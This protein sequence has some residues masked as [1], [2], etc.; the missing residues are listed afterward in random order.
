MGMDE[1]MIT[2]LEALAKVPLFTGL[3]PNELAR[4]GALV[5]PRRYRR[6]EVIFLEGDSGT[7][8][9][10]IALGQVKIVLSG[11]DGREV[12]LNVYG[13]GDFFGEFALLDG[14]PRSADAIAQEGCLLYWLTREDFLAFLEAHPRAAST[15][16]AVL[17]RRLR[18]TTRVVQD[19]TFR[20]VPARLARVVLDLAT[21]RGRSAGDGVVVE[22][23]VHPDRSRVDGGGQ[24]RDGE[25]GAAGVRARRPAPPRARSHYDHATRATPR[26][27]QSVVGSGQWAVGR[28]GRRLGA[29]GGF[30]PVL[31]G[32][33]RSDSHHGRVSG[34]RHQALGAARGAAPTSASGDAR[35]EAAGFAPSRS[36]LR[37]RKLLARAAKHKGARRP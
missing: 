14:E 8:L 29:G 36:P 31:A 6:G 18:H 20:D 5:R 34:H 16:L 22:G 30:A 24:P 32:G 37:T 27:R 35:G 17:S 3:P 7:S 2:G 21:T 10:V 1:P 12:V 23:T 19:A 13:P 28:V 15:L 33:N 11:A 25:Q 26:A 9:C 4:L